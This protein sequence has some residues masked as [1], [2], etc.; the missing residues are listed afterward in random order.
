MGGVGVDAGGGTSEESLVH[1]GWQ[2]HVQ[3]ACL[4]GCRWDGDRGAEVMG[5]GGCELVDIWCLPNPS[6]VDD[7]LRLGGGGW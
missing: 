2:G 4:E 5:E 7:V 6:D 1:R 3:G